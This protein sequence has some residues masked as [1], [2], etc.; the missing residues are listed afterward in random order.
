MKKNLFILILII[1][2]FFK[3]NVQANYEKLFYDFKIN[4]ISG[5]E[6]NFKDFENKFSLKTIHTD[7]KKMGVVI[8][9]SEFLSKILIHQEKDFE[10]FTFIEDSIK[11]YDDTI[12]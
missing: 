3:N 8:F 9:L 10:L 11:Y 7:Y 2:I 5:N 4:D 6:L 1:M 12:L